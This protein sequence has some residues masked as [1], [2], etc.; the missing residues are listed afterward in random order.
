MYERQVNGKFPLELD[1]Y[2]SICTTFL[3]GYSS[4]ELKEL[5]SQHSDNQFYGLEECLAVKNPESFKKSLI[6]EQY[7]NQRVAIVKVNTHL[8][9]R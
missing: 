3:V 6:K 2:A 9:N 1:M 4:K 7:I 5:Q 8:F